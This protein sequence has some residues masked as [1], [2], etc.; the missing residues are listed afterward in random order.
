MR[1]SA[2]FIWVENENVFFNDYI[3]RL[4]EDR[5]ESPEEQQQMDEDETKE[6]VVSQEIIRNHGQG[7]K[8]VQRALAHKSF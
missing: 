2:Y 4:L 1:F 3:A 7:Q 8:V 6:G 5:V